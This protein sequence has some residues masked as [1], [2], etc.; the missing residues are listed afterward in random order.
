MP[1]GGQ[2]YIGVQEQNPNI[3]DTGG[4]EPLAFGSEPAPPNMDP[5][6]EGLSARRSGKL[7]VLRLYEFLMPVATLLAHLLLKEERMP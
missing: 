2:I 7:R 5:V 6:R 4:R 3:L 1:N